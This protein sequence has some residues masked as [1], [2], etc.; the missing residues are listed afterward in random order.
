L[1]VGVEEDGRDQQWMH[2]LHRTRR[3]RLN[4]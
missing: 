1:V 4:D 3:P 2:L